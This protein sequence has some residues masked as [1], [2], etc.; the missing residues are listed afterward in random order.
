M[1]PLTDKA[2]KMV[3]IHLVFLDG[4]GRKTT[5]TP[6]KKS[7]RLTSR[8]VAAGACYRIDG[9]A[10]DPLSDPP[11]DP[12]DPKHLHR[13]TILCEGIEDAL[14][15]H[16]ACPF[17]DILGMPGV[18]RLKHHAGRLHGDT[19]VVY[20]A[21]GLFSAPRVW[22]TFRI[23]GMEKVFILDG[24][25]TKW[26]AENRPLEHH[27]AEEQHRAINGRIETRTRWYA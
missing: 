12:A 2:G 9:E 11:A 17:S 25:L 21:L 16:V 23:F 10:P 20:D 1:A 22:W 8:E 4:R 13:S 26:K 15:A 3:A 18:G 5:L 27:T 7:L 19:V 24:G 14:A 6:A